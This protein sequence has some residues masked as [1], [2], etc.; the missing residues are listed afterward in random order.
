MKSEFAASL[1]LED[2]STL[3]LLFS[4]AV[5]G[6]LQEVSFSLS[7]HASM[8]TFHL[9]CCTHMLGWP[10]QALFV[11]QGIYIFVI[12][13]F[14]P[15]KYLKNNLRFCLMKQVYK[16]EITTKLKNGQG[17]QTSNLRSKNLTK[18]KAQSATLLVIREI[19]IKTTVGHH[20]I[21]IIVKKFKV[22]FWR[23]LK[24]GFLHSLFMEVSVETTLEDNL[25]ILGKEN[26]HKKT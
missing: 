9:T 5:I 22:F 19:L 14:R 16:N 26:V 2:L 13:R 21:P 25:A 11:T 15:F 4:S 3:S 23:I 24:V 20:L 12:F 10:L 7:M 18:R 8:H 6:W 1:K 17:L